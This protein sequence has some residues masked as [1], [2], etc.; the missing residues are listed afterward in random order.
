MS[1]A[2]PEERMLKAGS[3]TI[4]N[5]GN[6]SNA[7]YRVNGKQTVLCYCHGMHLND[8]RET[9]PALHNNG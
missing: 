1:T 5:I 4:A 9:T 2:S 3:F 7:L 8:E 6:S